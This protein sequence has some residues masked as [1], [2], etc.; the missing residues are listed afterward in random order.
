MRRRHTM[1]VG[2]TLFFV[3]VAGT[4]LLIP[5]SAVPQSTVPQKGWQEQT[6]HYEVVENWPKLLTSLPGHE[7]W[8]W[9]SPEAIFA[10]NPDRIYVLQRGELPALTQR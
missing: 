3:L 1:T 2:T 8:T 7:K 5:K 6:G 9:G 4:L 10:E